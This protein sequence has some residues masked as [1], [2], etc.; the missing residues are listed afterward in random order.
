MHECDLCMEMLNL[1][2]NEER[3][4]LNLTDIEGEATTDTQVMWFKLNIQP[5][6][7]MLSYILQTL[8]YISKAAVEGYGF[9]N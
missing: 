1:P 5:P 3:I 9:F 4:L 2:Q 7:L 8:N 6:N